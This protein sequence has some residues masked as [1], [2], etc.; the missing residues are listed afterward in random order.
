M[1]GIGISK[2]ARERRAVLEAL[3]EVG[4]AGM[5]PWALAV[6]TQLPD[7]RLQRI[8]QRLM[9]TGLI[10][11]RVEQH[12]DGYRMGRARYRISVPQHRF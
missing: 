6:T 7:E 2:A 8:L 3:Q 4:D 10:T 1:I 9:D 12:R 5:T 11:R